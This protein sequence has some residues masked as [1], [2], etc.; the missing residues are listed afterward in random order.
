MLFYSVGEV[1]LRQ[2]GTYEGSGSAKVKALFRMRP[3]RTRCMGLD[4]G[5]LTIQDLDDDSQVSE[6]SDN[7][8]SSCL[9]WVQM[10]NT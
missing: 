10:G 3:N 9:S 6:M 5:Q 1:L 4:H 8:A 7:T 2:R